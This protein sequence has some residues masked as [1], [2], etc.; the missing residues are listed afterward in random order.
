VNGFWDEDKIRLTYKYDLQLLESVVLAREG[1]L[2]RSPTYTWSFGTF[3]Y[4]GKSVAEKAMLEKIESVGEAFSNRYLKVI[5]K[6]KKKIEQN[7]EAN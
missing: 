4:A 5:D 7:G 3:G 1:D 2:R 6:E